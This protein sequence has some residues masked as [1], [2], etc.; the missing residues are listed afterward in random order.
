MFL[1]H[2][3]PSGS[4]LPNSEMGEINTYQAVKNITQKELSGLSESLSETWEKRRV[5]WNS[6]DYFTPQGMA[7][8]E[9]KGTMP[10]NTTF[11]YNPI[12][13][14]SSKNVVMIRNIE[15]DNTKDIYL[16]YKK[17]IIGNSRDDA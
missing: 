9:K 3:I 6:I 15:V 12:P 1:K 2:E 11:E 14:N 17:D 13:L 10:T 16:A 8:G 4:S 7:T 5:G